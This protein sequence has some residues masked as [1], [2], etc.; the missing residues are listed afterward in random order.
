MTPPDP[1][2]PPASASDPRASAS[3][4]RVT[5]PEPP[6]PPA[7]AAKPAPRRPWRENIEAILMAIVVALLFKYFVLEISKIPSGSMQPT[8][9]GHPETATF[10]RTVV[11]KLSYQLRDPERFEIVVFKHPLEESRVMVKRLVGMPGEELKIENGDLFV[12]QAGGEWKNLRRPPA[13]MAAMWRSLAGRDARRATWSVVRGG[14][15]WSVGPDEIRARGPGA[16]RFHEKAGPILDGY[17]DG[18]P[19]ALHDAVQ[20]RDPRVGQTPVG[21]LRLEGRLVVL[22]GTES[23]TVELTEGQRVYEFTLPGPAAPQGAVPGILAR[24]SVAKSETRASGAALA[25]APGSTHTFALENL[26]DRLAL[27][28]DGAEL[29]AL[30]IAPNANQQASFTV[31]VKGEGAELT[32][33][34]VFRDIHYL[35]PERR[36]SWSV[37]IPPGSY[38]MLGDN[39]QDSADGRLW[40][41]K[42]YTYGSPTGPLEVRGNYREENENPSFGSLADGTPAIRFRDHL[43]ERHWFARDD[44]LSETLPGNEP[45]VARELILGR[46]LAVFWPIRPLDGLW[47][48]GWTR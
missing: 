7:S 11:D 38:V 33:L 37:T 23:V 20:A 18:Y 15:D 9:M 21:D 31:D 8:L 34:E 46:V 39:T 36:S 25:L 12:R 26:D 3:T 27:F 45:L 28:V 40:K 17:A 29:A 32:A 6:L 5:V 19:L 22:P 48:L 1:T 24:D 10:D 43:G 41:A 47:R 14:K 2:E 35:V 30:E 13:V 16:A 4:T 44:V 42:S